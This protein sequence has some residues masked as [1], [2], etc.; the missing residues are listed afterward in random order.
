MTDA[1]EI[2]TAHAVLRYLTRV[3]LFDI[4][5]A[6]REAGRTAGNWAIAERAA[7]LYG[8]PI[9]TL[10]RR[11]LPAHLVEAVLAGAERISLPGLVLVCRG[12]R[13]TSVMTR[14]AGRRRV[15]SKREIRTGLQRKCRRGRG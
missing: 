12:G 13:V 6:V 2:V 1:T 15:L 14:R 4:G 8:A 5:P 11:V 9:E 10:Q 7:R 3:E